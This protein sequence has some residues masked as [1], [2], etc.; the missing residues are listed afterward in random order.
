MLLCHVVNPPLLRW[1]MG[2]GPQYTVP[3]WPRFLFG[4]YLMDNVLSIPQRLPAVPPSGQAG[5]KVQQEIRQHLDE[6][7]PSCTEVARPWRSS[8]TAS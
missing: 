4:L 8:P 3:M 7:P 5:S 2:I 6:R 1:L